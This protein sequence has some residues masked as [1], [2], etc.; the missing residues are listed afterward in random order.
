MLEDVTGSQCNPAPPDPEVLPKNIQ[1]AIGD[2]TAGRG[3][4]VGVPFSIRA[5]RPS[6]G[7]AFSVD[8]DEGVLEA[9]DIVTGEVSLA[10]SDYMV[11]NIRWEGVPG[12][13]QGTFCGDADL[14]GVVNILDA[15][16]VAQMS[17]G[18]FTP[19]SLQICVSDVDGDFAATILDALRI[20]QASAGLPVTFVCP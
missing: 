9:T 19:T 3:E 14:N 13:I 6:Q 10:V 11:V 8:F 7:F 16:A 17:A 2:G 4:N 12:C 1:F 20:A 18:L 5:D 15:L